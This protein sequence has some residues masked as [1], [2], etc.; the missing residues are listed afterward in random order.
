MVG[1]RDSVFEIG[2]VWRQW[3][4]GPLIPAKRACA[5]IGRL[6]RM[7]QG[8]QSSHVPPL[9]RTAFASRPAARQAA[10]DLGRSLQEVLG[11]QASRLLSG[12]PDQVPC[13]SLLQGPLASQKM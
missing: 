10:P 9:E 4:T 11:S 12:T 7:A 8:G 6:S 3:S 13:A 5:D 1:R 2:I